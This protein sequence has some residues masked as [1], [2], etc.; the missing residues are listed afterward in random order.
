[1]RKLIVILITLVLVAG[2]FAAC[3]HDTNAAALEL[4]TDAKIQT[5]SVSS[6]PEGYSYS[7]SG[8]EAIA[9]IDYL[10]GL[11]LIAVFSENP[12][13]YAGMTWVIAIEYEDR[14]SVTVYHSCNLFVR[15]EDGPWYKM[16][17]DD[18]AEFARLLEELTK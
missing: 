6:L 16:D 15:T 12:N 4:P 10:S 9:I 3:G 11:N 18:A 14:D 8:D 1:M 7:F 5:V 2:I 13:E 17:F